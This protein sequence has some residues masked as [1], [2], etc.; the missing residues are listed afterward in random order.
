MT[1][2]YLIRHSVRIKMSEMEYNTSQDRLILN[3]KIILSPLGEERAK[4]LADEEELQNIDKVYCSNCV[5]TLQ[6]AKYLMEKQNL[7]CTIDDRLDERRTGIPND[8]EF[9]NWFELQYLDENFKTV[10][11]ES[12]LDVRNRF[13]EVIKE[14]LENYKDKR[15]CI[16]SHAYAITFYLLKYCKLEHVSKEKFTI[17]FKD[18]IVMDRGINAPE[19]FKLTFD[20]DNLYDIE[21]L[22]FDDLDY[23]FGV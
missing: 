17:K 3:E 9:P 5:R 22:D 19:V 1:T 12:Q 21:L 16:F 8:K 14:V 20:G 10:G 13:S 23:N 6:T 7:K 18:K 2:I 4:I 15:I 11:G